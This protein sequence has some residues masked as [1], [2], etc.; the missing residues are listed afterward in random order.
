MSPEPR[1]L[2]GSVVAVTG[3]A[4]GIG[5]ATA[6]ALLAHG[7]RVGI[8]DLE[9]DLAR[10]A[11]EQLGGGAVGFDLNVTQRPSFEAFLDGVEEQLGPVDVLINNAGIM[12]LSPLESEDDAQTVRMLDVNLAGVLI[13]CKAVLPGLK[14]RRRGHIVNVA[15]MAGKTGY[16]NAV[17]YCATKFAVVGASEALRAELRGSGVDVSVV[18]PVP[19]RTELGSGLAGARGI[20]PVEPEEVAD[21]IVEA[22]R[23]NRFDVFVPRKAGRVDKLARMLPRRAAEALGRA[24]KA[25]R[26]LVDADMGARA[27]YEARASHADPGVEERV[28]DGQT[29]ASTK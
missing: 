19:V 18:M 6:R 21:E 12:Q 14:G 27:A 17:T 22:L 16:A 28:A 5:K 8:G 20:D 24:M 23:V 15:S 25:D 1:S 29:T 7:A 10:Q 4:R 26:I 11:A 13:G 2:Y 3:G 9:G